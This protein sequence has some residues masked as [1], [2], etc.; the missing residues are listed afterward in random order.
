VTG[1]A[2]WTLSLFSEQGFLDFV[3][4]IHSSEIQAK[5]GRKEEQPSLGKPWLELGVSRATYFRRGLNRDFLG[6]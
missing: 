2:K 5:R 3:K 4:K 1:I 6:M